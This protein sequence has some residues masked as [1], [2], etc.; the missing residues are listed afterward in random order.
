MAYA[1]VVSTT[2]QGTPNS[3]TSNA[4]DTTGANLIVVSVGFY[5]GTSPTPTLTDSKSNTW[6]GLTAR[7]GG[8]ITNRLFYC[9]GGTVGSGHTFTLSDASIFPGMC[10]AAFSGSVS[11][12]IDQ[13]NGAG[14]ASGSTQAPGSVTPSENNEL[15]IA[16]LGHD[17][18]SAGAVSING[19]FTAITSAWLTGNA[20]GCGLAYLIQTT[21]TAANPTW[22]VTNSAAAGIA[23]SIATFKAAD[24]A[25]PALI[26]IRKS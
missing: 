1:L 18:N 19:G 3:V 22:D 2:K 24:A 12:P 6:S 5:N 21:A 20:E 11:S 9:F 8:S 14:S 25:T 4:I 17:D 23:A 10:V 15:I 13:E 7:V 16:G 26:V